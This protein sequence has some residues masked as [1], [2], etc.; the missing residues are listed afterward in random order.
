MAARSRQIGQVPGL[1]I[2]IAVLAVLALLVLDF[3]VEWARAKDQA[4]AAGPTPVSVNR[5]NELRLR[6]WAARSR[7]STSSSMR[8]YLTV[9][10]RSDKRI[11][12]VHL[13][14]TGHGFEPAGWIHLGA[15]AP[16]A[17]TTHPVDLKALNET[18]SGIITSGVH[19]RVGKS[20]TFTTV[21][22]G[23]VEVRTKEGLG[24]IL[25]RAVLSFFK[26]LA[27]PIVLV[28]LAYAVQRLQQEKTSH[29]ETF[30]A[31]LPR[32]HENIVRFLL[33]IL[34]SAHRFLRYF[35]PRVSQPSLQQTLFNLLFILKGMRSL[36]FKGGGIFFTN[37]TGETAVQACWR[38]I[39][40]IVETKFGA[41]QVSE[42][43]DEWGSVESFTALKKKFKTVGE[44][45]RTSFAN[46]EKTLGEWVNQG[47][48]DSDLLLL[49]L[50]LRVFYDVMQ[51]EIDKIYGPWY[52]DEP[53]VF[54]QASRSELKKLSEWKGCP[55]K[56]RDALK[57][58]EG[59]LPAPKKPS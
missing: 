55:E 10:N 36:V 43:L 34:S 5:T 42:I 28:L 26:D 31:M 3:W 39:L 14:F 11:D 52:R 21:A 4:G 15:F 51:Y 44:P 12:D 40:G 54:E 46:M 57:E 33:P 25:S 13:F 35:D 22:I 56:L 58:F 9:E 20:L 16:G 24:L 49:I 8:V 32:A 29:Q 37:I 50:V 59:S 17:A 45:A 6:G 23:P 19:W 41:Q 30:H 1:W 18:S 38:E 7:V 2:L 48:I 53:P 27:L 47:K